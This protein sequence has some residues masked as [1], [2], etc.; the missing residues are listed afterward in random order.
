MEFFE[1]QAGGVALLGH[2]PSVWFLS[3][4]LYLLLNK[5]WKDFLFSN[6]H[7]SERMSKEQKLLY[8]QIRPRT[9]RRRS[10]LV[11]KDKDIMTQTE[12]DL[13]ELRIE[14]MLTEYEK[15]LPTVHQKSKK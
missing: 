8:H 12:D 7:T 15:S 1:K 4:F 6:V 5:L 13:L 10:P 11:V 3:F 9:S 14:E 2:S